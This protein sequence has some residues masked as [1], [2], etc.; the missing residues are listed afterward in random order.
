MDD[1]VRPLWSLQDVPFLAVQS[2]PRFA[3][4]EVVNH[5]AWRYKASRAGIDDAYQDRQAVYGIREY[6]LLADDLLKAGTE[7]MFFVLPRSRP[8]FDLPEMTDAEDPN[9]G[10]RRM[11]ATDERWREAL[12]ATLAQRG[13]QTY[14][15]RGFFKGKGPEDKVYRDDG[16]HLD[17][18]GH[19]LYTAFLEDKV[20]NE[21]K[22]FQDWRAGRSLP[23]VPKPGS[24]P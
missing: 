7:V 2:P 16:L 1:V 17:T 9:G 21:S 5:L 18:L 13:V 23:V 3:W 15:A 12:T 20:Q 4:E 8:G 19:H 6:G 14:F 22:R 11:Y 10:A 24:Q